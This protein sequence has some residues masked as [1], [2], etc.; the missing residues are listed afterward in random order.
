MFKSIKYRKHFQACEPEIEKHIV[1]GVNEHLTKA[2][3]K[4]CLTNIQLEVMR[5]ENASNITRMENED[6]LETGKIEYWKVGQLEI[7]PFHIA[8]Q[9]KRAKPAFNIQF[10]SSSTFNLFKISK[11]EEP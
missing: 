6:S 10:S 7:E 8:K 1:F 9:Y 11:F 5:R 4:I 2:V 3:D